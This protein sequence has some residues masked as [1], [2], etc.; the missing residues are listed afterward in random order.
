M[1]TL[2]PSLKSKTTLRE[3][4]NSSRRRRSRS[5]ERLGWTSRRERK[6]EKSL[7]SS[8]KIPG[9]PRRWATSYRTEKAKPR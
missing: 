6:F 5:G 9:F 1:P 8:M 2:I 7:S 3:R 4:K